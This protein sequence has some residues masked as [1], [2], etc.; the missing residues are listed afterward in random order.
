M[1]RP[2]G[3]PYSR[4]FVLLAEIPGTDLGLWLGCNTRGSG[5]QRVIELL[6]IVNVHATGSQSNTDIEYRIQWVI[7]L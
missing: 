1:R 4:C 2:A 6:I 5:E 7:I 3:T